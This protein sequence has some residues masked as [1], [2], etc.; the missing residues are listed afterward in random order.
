LLQ[1]KQ[2]LNDPQKIKKEFTEL[3]QMSPP[4]EGEYKSASQ[5]LNK[6]KNRYV[7]VLPSE[8]TRVV[9]NGSSES[10]YINANWITG[11]VPG[12]EKQF[13]ATQGPLPNTVGDFW[14]MVWNSRSSVVL[15]LTKVLEMDRMKCFTY[16][17]EP[18]KKILNVDNDLSIKL[19]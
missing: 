13:I 8:Q 3:D 4:T 15:M 18:D 5:S 7:N 6:P 11:L 19:L 16:W 12:S 10:D 9:L 14:L 2:S 1:L 17:P